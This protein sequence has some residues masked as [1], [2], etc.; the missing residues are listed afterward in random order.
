[1]F[2]R[3]RTLI[4]Y[5]IVILSLVLG[6]RVYRYFFETALPVIALQG[7]DRGGYYAGNIQCVLVGSHPYKVADINVWLDGVPLINKFRIGKAEFEHPFLIT[8][9]ALPN[10]AHALKIEAISG[11]YYRTKTV[12]ERT[13]YVDNVPLQAAFVRSDTDLRVFQG[14]TLHVQFQVNKDIKKA[15]V[16]ALSQTF[17][18]VPESKNST[19]YE[20]FIPISCEEVPNEYVL[21]V[22]II[23]KVGSTQTLEAKF[24]VIQFP[25]K[26][27][28]LSVNSQAVQKEAELGKSHREMND[29]LEQISAA[30]VPQKLWR[31]AFCVPMDMT[32]VT[33]EFGTIRTTPDRGRYAH[34]AV[35]FGGRQKSVIWA[36]Q[37]GIVAVKDRFARSGNTVVIDHGCGVL[38]CYAHLD[39]FADIAV[40]QRIEKGNP[41]GIMGKTGYA[42]GDH[43]HWEMRINN[44]QV[45]PLQWTKQ[46]F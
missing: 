7:L 30:S 6:Y 18:C 20:A 14:R 19:I 42:T 31:G 33:C 13:F 43:L 23:D 40:G 37:S 24:Q 22:E 41:V 2:V 34:N 28:T 26:K 44:I 25:F 5:G 45:D 15:A 4:T 32:A 35:D 8:S 12:D 17:T 21:S 11:A 27:Q 3:G 16:L 36:A 39:S 38:T 29:I 1:M 9:Q 10:G 46:N